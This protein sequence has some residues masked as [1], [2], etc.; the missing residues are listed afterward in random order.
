[1]VFGTP[2]IEDQTPYGE[3]I[4]AQIMVNYLEVNVTSTVPSIIPILDLPAMR[5]LTDLCWPLSEDAKAAHLLTKVHHQMDLWK[6][7]VRAIFNSFDDL[8]INKVIPG[9]PFSLESSWR[10]AIETLPGEV[11]IVLLNQIGM[12][13]GSTG[14]NALTGTVP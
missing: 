10:E 13:L 2:C 11:S 7:P 8:D 12:L 3:S 6:I 9:A 1:M 5:T 14:S 4:Q